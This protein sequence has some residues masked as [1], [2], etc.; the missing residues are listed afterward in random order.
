MSQAI[1]DDHYGLDAERYAFFHIPKIIMSRTRLPRF[2][3]AK[4]VLCQPGRC[5][6]IFVLCRAII[7]FTKIISCTYP[8]ETA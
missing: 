6:F 2:L 7:K 4:D 5:Y 1:V 8:E 3:R